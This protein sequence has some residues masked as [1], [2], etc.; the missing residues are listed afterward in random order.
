MWVGGQR[1]SSPTLPPA[2]SQFRL[3]RRLGGPQDRDSIAGPSSPQRVAIPLSYLIHVYRYVSRVVI[4]HHAVQVLRY[5]ISLSPPANHQQMD[6]PQ[7]GSRFDIWLI[8]WL[9]W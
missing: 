2:Q 3:Y 5:G 1:Y 8:E 4:T 7:S 6:L 9:G